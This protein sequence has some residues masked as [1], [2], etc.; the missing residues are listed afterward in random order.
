MFIQRHEKTVKSRL[1]TLL[2]TYNSLKKKGP[3]KKGTTFTNNL[4]DFNKLSKGLFDIR[5]TDIS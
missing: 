2:N 4:K 1:E 5:C 3:D